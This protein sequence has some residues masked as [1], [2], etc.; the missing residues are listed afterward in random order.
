MRRKAVVLESPLHRSSSEI[1]HLSP[2]I[3]KLSMG[4]KIIL[5][6]RGYYLSEIYHFSIYY[7]ADTG[8]WV[9]RFFLRRNNARKTVATTIPAATAMEIESP[10]PSGRR[11][12]SR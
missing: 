7:A 11:A 6:C 9:N 2:T 10:K 3:A 12:N 8:V 4:V 5:R 1:L